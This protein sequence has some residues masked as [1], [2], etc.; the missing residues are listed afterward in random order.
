[1]S[2]RSNV[3]MPVRVNV[4]PSVPVKKSYAV[5]VKG[6]NDKMSSE[7]VR[8]KVL[9]EVSGSVN[10]RVRAIRNVREGVAVETVSEKECQALRECARFGD[11]GLRVETPR[12]VGPRII[13]YDVPRGLNN[14]WLT[15]ELY[16]RNVRGVIE[17]EDFLLKSRV[18]A[19]NGRKEVNVENVILEVPACV[20]DRLMSERR[21]FVG[22]MAFRMNEYE[23]VFRC[24]GCYGFTHRISECKRER[25]C[26]KCSKPGHTG[27][28]C[29]YAPHCAN[30]SAKNLPAGHAI[31]SSDCPEYVWRLNVLRSRCNG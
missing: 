23:R 11:A 15:S 6:V 7:E 16:E 24:Y 1:M 17:K 8:A 12:R 26:S 10:V 29:T 13:V 22:W 14:E 30:C 18:I 28:E 3:G 19:R 2:E 25:L 9:N 4:A 31:L 21:V 20:R 5:I 27:R